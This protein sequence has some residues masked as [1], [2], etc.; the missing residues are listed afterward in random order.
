[1]TINRYAIVENGMVT[2]VILWDGN[3]ETWQPPMGSTANLLPNDS[4]VGPGWTFDGTD[5]AG[6]PILNQHTS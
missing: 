3:T 1:M 5:Y 4:P 6:P 2:N